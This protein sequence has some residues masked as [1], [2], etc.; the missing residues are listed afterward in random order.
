MTVVPPVTALRSPPD[1]R[2]TGADSPV[3][4]DSFTRAAPA[5]TSP[6]PAII[7]CAS[8]RI[9]VTLAQLAGADGGVVAAELRLVQALGRDVGA[10]LA[11]AGGAGLAAPLGQRLGKGGEDH[12]QPE[13]ERDG[14]GEPGRFRVGAGQRHDEGDQGDDAGDLHAEHDRIAPE[15]AGVEFF[16]GFEQGAGLQIR[17]SKIDMRLVAYVST[18]LSYLPAWSDVRRSAPGTGPGKRSARRR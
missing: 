15:G 17:A 14:A 7:S 18:W 1:S 9:I 8:T 16:E 10:G 11:Q 6:S 4:A 12:R 3:T 5:T 13:P 2:T